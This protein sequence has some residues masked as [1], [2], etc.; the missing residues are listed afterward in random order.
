MANKD[1]HMQYVDFQHSLLHDWKQSMK[2]NRMLL[3]YYS[4]TWA[5]T[6]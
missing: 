4:I 6:V 3:S 1:S 2:P 5:V